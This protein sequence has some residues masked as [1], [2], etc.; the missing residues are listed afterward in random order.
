MPCY[1]SNWLTFMSRQ[2]YQLSTQAAEQ[3]H[4]STH[5][6]SS[7][8]SVRLFLLSLL[9]HPSFWSFYFSRVWPVQMTEQP[10]ELAVI[11]QGRWQF[12]YLKIDTHISIFKTFIIDLIPLSYLL[13]CFFYLVLLLFLSCHFSANGPF[14][15]LFSR[16]LSNIF[17]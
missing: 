2:W 3:Y 6:R 14:S 15:W 11:C 4:M 9:T 7:N 1:W 5:Q 10:Q 8:R 17:R 16:K 13:S 12:Q